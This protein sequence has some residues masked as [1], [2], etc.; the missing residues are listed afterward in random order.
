MPARMRLGAGFA[1]SFAMAWMVGAP[2]WVGLPVA[3]GGG[4][5]VAILLG[6]LQPRSQRDRSNRLLADLPHACEL[7]AACLDAGLPLRSATRIVGESLGGP[8][9]EELGT[10]T[11]QVQ[12]GIGDD[13]AWRSLDHPVLQRLGRDLAR[14]AATGVV[15]GAGLRVHAADATATIAVARQEQARKV[16]VMSVMPLMCCYLPAFVLLGIV[17]VVGGFVAGLLGG[18]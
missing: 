14:T 15:A 18:G 10:V 9:G 16:G 5:A 6:R 8:I 12:L 13:E 3:C 1:G 11:A 7:I 4:A 2:W 17:P